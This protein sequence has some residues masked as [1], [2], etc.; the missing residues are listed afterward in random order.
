MGKTNKETYNYAKQFIGKGGSTFRSYCGLP[1]GAAWCNAF[2]TYIFHKTDNANLYCGGKKQTYCPTSIKWCKSNLAQIPLYLAMPM[3]VIYFDWDKNGVPN[4]IGFVRDKKDTGSIYTIEGNTDGGKVA[5]KTRPAKYVQAVYRPHYKPPKTITKHKLKIDG[6]FGFNSIY[7]LQVALGGLTTDGVLG[8]KTIKRL[9]Q[10]AG[11]TQDGCWQKGTSRA[12]QKL[13]GAKQ[14]GDF[15]PASVRKL[16]EWINKKAFPSTSAKPVTAAKPSAQAEKA[17]AWGRSI[18]KSGKYKYKKFNNKDKKTK[19]CPICHKLTGKYRGWNC[20][21]YV[22]ACFFHTGL[23]QIKCACNGIG[24]DSFFTKVTQKSWEDRNGKGWKMIGSGSKGGASLPT[25]QLLAGDVLIGYDKDG[26]FHH[27]ALYAGNG[28][29]LE[30]TKTRKPN[31][32]ER[33]YADLCSRHHVT[34]AFRYTG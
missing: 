9:Q 11:C 15:G 2:V 27:V 3:D 1:S 17:V 20:I 26:K 24:T 25:S 14:D 8:V 7:M 12:V 10:V 30:S 21:G 16:Q 6:D 19:Q 4:H 34:R 18:A 29:I 5:L 31:V 23:K 33:T 13:V 28:K 32:G 22:S